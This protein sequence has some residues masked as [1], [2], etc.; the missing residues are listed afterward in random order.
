M[1]VLR[2]LLLTVPL[3]FACDG[4]DK[5]GS[6]LDCGEGTHDE[7]GSCVPDE[8]A[9]ADA[10]AD[11][12][13]D[14][15]ADADSDADADADSDADADADADDT[16]STPIDADGDGFTP[17]DGDC[18]DT[19]ALVHPTAIDLVGDEI[20][21]DCDGIDGTDSDS[22][23][24]AA[25]TTGGDDCNDEDSSVNPEAV[26]EVC[27][28][29][30]NDCDG[31]IDAGT[32]CISGVRVNEEP[33]C[34][35][36]G[37]SYVFVGSGVTWI[38]GYGVEGGDPRTSWDSARTNCLD[39][40]YDLAII[41]DSCEWDWMAAQ[42]IGGGLGDKWWLSLRCPDGV[43]CESGGDST[44]RWIDGSEGYIGWW[45]AT[46]DQTDCVRFTPFY[47]YPDVLELG[48]YP[49]QGCGESLMYV[50]E[51]L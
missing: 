27:D 3:A 49:D 48:G 17:D 6:G 23:G 50:C 14:A 18:D 12:D 9:D 39:I 21:M 43:S 24:Y 19:N 8:D 40:G 2:L 41:E 7:D 32:E 4:D 51:T 38:P 5:P 37:H 31:E 25:V 11:A 20:D 44:Y 26:E 35:S 42:M 1:K 22:D 45:S 36:F 13:S 29:I 15:D 28:G 16:G 46:L 10:D 30:D 34:A 33:S 47:A